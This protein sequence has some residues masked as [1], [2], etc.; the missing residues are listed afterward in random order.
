MK[1]I[2]L[3]KRNTFQWFDCYYADVDHKIVNCFGIE[4]TMVTYSIEEM[5]CNS[6]TDDLI[7]EGA[8]LIHDGWQFLGRMTATQIMLSIIGAYFLGIICAIIRNNL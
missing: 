2:R 4:G 1:P 5:S 6:M 3:R 8:E 7:F